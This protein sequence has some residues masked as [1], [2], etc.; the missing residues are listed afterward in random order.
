MALEVTLRD[1]AGSGNRAN[2][3]QEGNVNVVLH[4]HP[5][6]KNDVTAIPFS[7][8][9]LN[10]GSNDMIVDGSTT[11]VNFEIRSGLRDVFIRTI[12]IYIADAGSSID[13]FGG[14]TALTN[15]LEFYY[16]ND[17]A[18]EVLIQDE[19][20]TNLDLVRLGQQTPGFGDKTTAFQLSVSG[21]G[22]DAYLPLIDFSKVFGF[23]WGLKLQSNKNDRLFFR[24]NDN[25]AGLDVFNIKAF[26]LQQ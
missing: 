5:P 9:F 14:L 21:G 12:S 13:K 10:A 2:I 18:G 17:A 26:G 7:Q 15:G 11:P 19:I 23:G 6:F 3:D 1:G 25:L 24:V 16:Y 8:Y 20:K 22:S 4:G